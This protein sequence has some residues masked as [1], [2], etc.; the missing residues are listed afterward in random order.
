MC[1]TT[2]HPNM[3]PINK[4]Y[5]AVVNNYDNPPNPSNKRKLNIDYIIINYFVSQNSGNPDEGVFVEI[6]LKR[7]LI[8]EAR[9]DQENLGRGSCKNSFL[10]TEAPRS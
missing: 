9:T 4:V 5:D 1:L 10:I 7:R 3:F 2:F 6:L 8:N